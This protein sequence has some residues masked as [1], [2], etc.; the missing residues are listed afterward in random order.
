V[1][2]ILVVDDEHAICQ[3]FSKILQLEGHTP[4]IAA[5]GNEALELARSEQPE[6]VFMDI[7]MPGSDGLSTLEQL[8]AEFPDLPVIIMT[9]YGTVD[10]AMKAMQLG[11]FD[12]LGK[13]VELP[14]I[15][16]LL[17]RAL[18]KPESTE[19]NPASAPPTEQDTL[20]GQSAP[21]QEVFKLRQK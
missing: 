20:I 17:A 5:N 19:D 12:Y 2:K 9:A 21:M 13:P 7:Q 15:R 6:V 18:H 1:S 16:S 4:L 10:T 11:A 8:Q 14:Q 3:A